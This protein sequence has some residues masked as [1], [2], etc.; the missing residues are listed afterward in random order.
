MNA[1]TSHSWYIYVY[2]SVFC[3][4]H[5]GS[6]LLTV[7]FRTIALGWI[8]EFFLRILQLTWRYL[9]L[10]IS[11]LAVGVQHAIKLL[12]AILVSNRE[13]GALYYLCFIDVLASINRL[14]T[15][16][17]HAASQSIRHL[18]WLQVVTSSFYTVCLAR[19]LKLDTLSPFFYYELL[20]LL[21]TLAFG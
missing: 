5:A 14:H 9:S 2:L 3:K 19:L 7:L 12:P 21:I 8:M 10:R 20:A 15:H 4:S 11:R 18:R 1:T 17:F 6:G 13:D 16:C